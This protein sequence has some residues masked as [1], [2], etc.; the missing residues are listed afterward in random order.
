MAKLRPQAAEHGT[1]VSMLGLFGL[2]IAKGTAGYLTGS[3]ALIADACHSA[4]DFSGAALS[5][6]AYR[7][8][9]RPSRYDSAGGRSSS[10]TLAGVILSALLLV[11]GL[12]AGLASLRSMVGGVTEP[13]GWSAV[14]VIVAGIA[15]R[16]ALIRY[17]KSHESKLGIRAERTGGEHRSDIFS[18]LTAIVGTAGAM[19]GDLLNMPVLYV[20]DPA[21]GLVI[22]VFVI[23]MGCQT[24]L[25]VT[26][27]S[28]ASALGELDYQA[29]LEAIQRVEGVVTV[30]QLKARESG[31][32]VVVEAV[33]RV[34]PRITVFEGHD[35]AMRVRRH[36]TKRFLHVADACIQ[37]E[38]FDPGYPY[39]SNH[40][41]EEMP[42]LMQ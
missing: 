12:E 6:M 4:A 36:L 1:I 37:V 40:H 31:H 25:A 19:A 11:A 27:P 32:Y 21:A 17:K 13:P 42:I 2:T 24:V 3:K 35:I 26:R 23:R 7:S 29:L 15:V 20:L 38:P 39:K 16:E 30:D 18:S 8:G 28:A 41:E 14:A 33:I 9:R 5:C 10:E 22:S 34:N